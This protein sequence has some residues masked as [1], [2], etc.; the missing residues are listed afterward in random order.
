[1]WLAE[2]L[3]LPVMLPEEQNEPLDEALNVAAWLLACGVLLA[4]ELAQFVNIPL[5]LDEGELLL[6][7]EVDAVLV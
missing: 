2:K 3:L 5:T 1:V 6:T 4:D 7:A